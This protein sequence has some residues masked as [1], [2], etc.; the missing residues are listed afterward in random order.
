[1]GWPVL[2]DQR[3]YVKDMAIDQRKLEITALTFKIKSE[4]LFA[5]GYLFLGEN[6]DLA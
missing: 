1:M 6:V 2:L 3:L 4:L 5:I